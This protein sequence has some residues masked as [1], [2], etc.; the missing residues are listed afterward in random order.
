MSKKINIIIV[1]DNKHY[2]EALKS[3]LLSL[4]KEKINIINNASSGKEFINTINK[5]NTDIV[6]MDYEMPVMNGLEATRIALSNY[7]RL[8]IIALSLYDDTQYVDAMLEAGAKGY[9][10]KNSDNNEIFMKIIKNHNE[11]KFFSK[12]I[13]YQDLLS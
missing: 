6:F 3:L 10:L 13:N 4:G 12:E 11:G 9:L 7:P 1:D 5:T 2:R 8:T